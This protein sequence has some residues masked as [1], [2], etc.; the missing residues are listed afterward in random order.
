MRYL[1]LTLKHKWFVFLAGQKLGVPLYLLI[2]HDWSK[3]SWDELPH[4]QRQFFGDAADPLGFSYAWNHH[5]KANKHHWEYWIPI[6]GHSKGGYQDMSPLPMPEKYALEMI[7]DFMG[8]NRAYEGKWPGTTWPWWEK[9]R[10]KILS[11]CHRDT[12][13][14]LAKYM[15]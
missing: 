4:Y 8:A 10:D 3:F 7:A 2:L 6:T 11:H 15:M 12:I 13:V 5:Q 1:L 9:N 14:L